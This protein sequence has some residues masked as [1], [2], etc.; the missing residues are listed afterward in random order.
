[1]NNSDPQSV[2]REDVYFTS[3]LQVHL[4]EYVLE[5]TEQI[6]NR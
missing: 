1:M 2:G 4:F 5:N 6:I 3:I